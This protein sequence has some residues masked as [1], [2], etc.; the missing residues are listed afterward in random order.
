MLNSYKIYQN[1]NLN[2]NSGSVFLALIMVAWC[3]RE[4]NSRQPPLNCDSNIHLSVGSGSES[5][6]P[7]LHV[8][9]GACGCRTGWILWP[10]HGSAGAARHLCD[11]GRKSLSTPS[12]VE[13]AV[14]RKWI[15]HS[16]SG[17]KSSKKTLTTLPPVAWMPITFPFLYKPTMIGTRIGNM[18][19]CAHTPIKLPEK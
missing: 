5:S 9:W 14:T 3:K 7:C 12:T 4:R 10:S 19:H 18:F 6:C 2:F 1:V 17:K 15:V 13:L 11:G 16:N 8:G